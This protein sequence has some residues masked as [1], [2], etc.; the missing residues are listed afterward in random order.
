MLS[1]IP[2]PLVHID[3]DALARLDYTF[4]FQKDLIREV[5]DFRRDRKDTAERIK[6]WKEAKAA[7]REREVERTA[8]DHEQSAVTTNGLVSAMPGVPAVSTQHA[9]ASGQGNPPNLGAVPTG[10][11]LPPAL[12]PRRDPS[13]TSATNLNQAV[14][15]GGGGG[16]G[17]GTPPLDAGRIGGNGSYLTTTPPR[18]TGRTGDTG[19]STSVGAGQ[20]ALSEKPSLLLPL[21]RTITLAHSVPVRS[22]KVPT[23]H[24]PR[25]AQMSSFLTLNPC[26]STLAHNPKQV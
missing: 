10:R 2:Q 3:P 15:S 12:P 23:P 25:L 26:L 16:G 20:L 19:V 22:R 17:G 7:P 21:A 9:P 11:P 5:E 1:V 18:D 4:Q 8:T 14:P 13:A 6:K 24:L